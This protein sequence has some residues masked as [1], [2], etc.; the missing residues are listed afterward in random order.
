MEQTLDA[1]SGAWDYAFSAVNRN[2]IWVALRKDLA[3]EWGERL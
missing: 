3:E 1:R 2:L